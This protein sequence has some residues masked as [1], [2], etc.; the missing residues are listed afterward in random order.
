MFDELVSTDVGITVELVPLGEGIELDLAPS[1]DLDER[2]TLTNMAVEAGGFTGIIEADDVVLDYL[3]QQRGVG[4]SELEARVGALQAEIARIQAEIT[5]KKAH[6]AAA[7][8]L[9]KTS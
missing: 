3:E 2:A 8:A 9:F 1:V 6:T 4:R 5:A 7:S